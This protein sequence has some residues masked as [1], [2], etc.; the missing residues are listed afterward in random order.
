MHPL[1]SRPDSPL[2][3]SSQQKWGT[4]S[5]VGVPL[6]PPSTTPLLSSYIQFPAYQKVVDRRNNIILRSSIKLYPS[7]IEPIGAYVSYAQY[8]EHTFTRILSTISR[9][10]VED[11]PLVFK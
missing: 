11:F 3:V 8:V 2:D 5:R 10:L 7:V 6:R 9:P 4:D 1:H